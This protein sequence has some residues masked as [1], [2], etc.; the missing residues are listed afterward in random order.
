[1]S[2]ELGGGR[3]SYRRISKIR[4]VNYSLPILAIEFVIFPVLAILPSFYVN[5]S[6]GEL[7]SYATAILI[8]RLVYSCSGPVVGYLSDRFTTRWGRRKPWMV[9]GTVVEVISVYLVFVP[10]A[11]AGPN[12]FAWTAA[13]ALLGFSMIDVPY[14]AW[15]SELTRDYAGR[16][17]IASYRA[18]FAV[19]GQVVFLALPMTPA[20]GGKNLLEASTIAR[21]G[22]VAMLLLMVTMSVALLWGP[23]AEAEE[24]APAE[25]GV[26]ALVADMVRNV[27]MLYLTGATV[28]AFLGYCMQ[29]TIALQFM[30]SIG[31]ASAFSALTLAGL[32]LSI[33]TVPFWEM[34]TK[35][36]GKNKCW[37]AALVVSFLG[38]PA[39]FV[40]APLF[41]T[42]A[43]LVVSSIVVA[44]PNTYMLTSLPYSIMGDVIDYDELKSGSNRSANYSAIILLVIRLQVAIGGAIAFFILSAMRFDVHRVSSHAVQPAMIAAYFV[45]P[46]VFMLLALACT[47][48]FPLDARRAAIVRRR[49][50]RRAGG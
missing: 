28:F 15:G 45:V 12:Y 17:L 14:I 50:E 3:G 38:L 5:F 41:G 29:L 47:W 2:N 39:Y 31:F 32:V 19:L 42:F 36:V 18:V 24:T 46:G 22:F 44:L 37:A 1:M 27:P 49:L 13:L 30:A 26:F 40:V 11:H 10:P 8:S 6:G 21:L 33:L 48:P 25:A 23:K 20:F 9:A 4:L 43:A 7:A 34:V 35:R 16:S